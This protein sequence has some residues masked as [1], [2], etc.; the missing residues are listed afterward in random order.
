[1]V[2]WFMFFSLLDGVAAV[3]VTTTRRVETPR[4]V[5][6]LLEAD[7]GPLQVL[8]LTFDIHEML[9][10]KEDDMPACR[11]S[12]VFH[13][14]DHADF[15]QGQPRRLSVTDEP[16][17]I[18][19]VHAVPA[20]PIRGAG[21]LREQPDR[22]VVAERLGGEPGGLCHLSYLHLLMIIDRANLLVGWKVREIQREPRGARG[23]L[24]CP[25]ETWEG[26]RTR[27]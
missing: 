25:S 6:H 13:V 24:M 1:M 23:S 2:V 9:F 22:L 5:G 20:V 8:D 26:E 11:L 21:R 17:S 10:Q 14:E 16:H 18:Y 3:R 4:P 19:R 12:A 27:L 15:G 7:L